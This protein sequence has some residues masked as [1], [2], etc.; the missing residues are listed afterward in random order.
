MFPSFLH[1]PAGSFAPFDSLNTELSPLIKALLV[2]DD[3]FVT[4]FVQ[5]LITQVDI[6]GSK[7]RVRTFNA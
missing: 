5:S 7:Q 1:R 2:I 6:A 3:L 4:G